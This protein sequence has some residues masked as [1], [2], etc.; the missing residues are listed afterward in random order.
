MIFSRLNK[1]DPDL[2]KYRPLVVELTTGPRQLEF[3][4]ECCVEVAQLVLKED[5]SRYKLLSSI[6]K[7]LSN[8]S[9]KDELMDGLDTLFAKDMKKDLVDRCYKEFEITRERAM[10][11][12]K[13]ASTVV[14][15]ATAL[16]IKRIKLAIETRQR[17]Y[18]RD[19][20]EDKL[21]ETKGLSLDNEFSKLDREHDGIVTYEQFDKLLDIYE[22]DDLKENTR[23]YLKDILDLNRTS[24][25]TLAYIK[26]VFDLPR[27]TTSDHDGHF[28][29]DMKPTKDNYREKEDE[30]IEMNARKALRRIYQKDNLIDKLSK[31]LKVYDYD[32]DGVMH[33]N[34][35]RQSIQD[36]TK[37]VHPDDVDYIT[38]YAD[39]RNKGYFNPEIFLDNIIKVAQ[40][41]A[42]KDALLRRVSNVLKHRNID[43]NNEL[44]KHSKTTAGIIDTYDFMRAMRELRIGF[45]GNDMEDLIRYASQGEKFIEIKPF[46][47]MIE[48]VSSTKPIS[49]SAPKSKKSDIAGKKGELSEIEQKRIQKK[50]E[51]LTNQLWDAKKELEKV[52]KNAQDWKAIAEKNEKS[53]NI[54]SDKLLDPKDKLKKMGDIQGE[55]SSAKVLKQQLRQQERILE[56]NEKIDE[57][58]ARN[59]ELEK[60]IKVEAQTQLSDFETKAQ[61]AQKKYKSIKSENLT[62]QNQIDKLVNASSSF[63]KNEEAEYARQLNIKNLEERIRELE[64]SERDLHEELLRSEHQILDMKFEKENNN[65]KLS[66]LNDKIRDL[67]NYIEIY[68][69]LPPS[70]I[71]KAGQKGFDLETELSRQPGASKRPATELEKVI[72]G[73]KRVINTQKAELEQFKKK[74]SKFAKKD[75]KVSTNKM[76]KD[77]IENLE[78]ELK[79]IEEKDKEIAELMFKNQKMTEANKALNNDIKNEQ[80]RYEFL[81]SKYKE[82]LVKYNVTFKDLEKKQ[83][84]L[85]TMS[86]GANRAT[87]QEYLNH[88]ENLK[89]QDHEDTS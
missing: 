85:F 21:E 77:E 88:K 89:K 34:I 52:E 25:I 14:D 44:S 38:Q 84:S 20:R 39:K 41:E 13:F 65:L 6:N 66:R 82:L 12:E 28:G 48:D 80:K 40:D 9:T 68:T 62:L 27:S 42:K 51:A 61:N 79:T 60:F 64:A 69:Q 17:E 57:L 31:Q 4:P 8:K 32:R 73:L 54:L 10:D 70:M 43:L 36:V 37:D 87:Y 49:V 75:D 33:R 56:L 83:D 50:I 46:C 22:M 67:E 72:E 19:A 29:L 11:A 26:Q 5:V 63:E 35:L 76:L 71:A 7:N 78:K 2:C 18:A 1:D 81:E 24:T 16:A 59:E 23:G 15:A 53:L 58:Q 3:L 45:D 55:G 30:E 86:T 74:E 47:K